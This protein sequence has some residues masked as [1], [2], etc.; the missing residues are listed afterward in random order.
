MYRII[1]AARREIGLDLNVDDS[2]MR[3]GADRVGR[4]MRVMGPAVA[5][6]GDST[7]E[8]CHFTGTAAAWLGVAR[9]VVD[10]AVQ[11]RAKGDRGGLCPASPAPERHGERK[12]SDKPMHGKRWKREQRDERWPWW[13]WKAGAAILLRPDVQRGLRRVF[14]H[15]TG[16]VEDHHVPVRDYHRMPPRVDQYGMVQFLRDFEV[17]PLLLTP[18]EASDLLPRIRN[19]LTVR[20]KKRALRAGLQ[21]SNRTNISQESRMSGHRGSPGE[22]DSAEKE[23]EATLGLEQTLS[24]VPVLADGDTSGRV[25]V[26]RSLT[27][28]PG[29]VDGMVSPPPG[30]GGGNGVSES[31]VDA[32]NN[33]DYKGVH[34]LRSLNADDSFLMATGKGQFDNSIGARSVDQTRTPTSTGKAHA[35]MA[36]STSE[37]SKERAPTTGGSQAEARTG[38]GSF[39]ANQTPDAAIG[40]GNQGGDRTPAN[41]RSAE[42]G[43]LNGSARSEGDVQGRGTGN[44]APRGLFGE[45]GEAEKQSRWST[46]DI[47]DVDGGLSYGTFVASIAQLAEVRD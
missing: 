26:T 32:A 10:G 21:S 33:S 35:H 34:S 24:P 22:V 14:D 2:V 43:P 8:L 47:E 41:W 25:D 36:A 29:S 17:V 20:E 18:R 37:E 28:S 6:R 38:G 23:D 46:V 13:N 1:Q 40:G 19:M 27:R 16:V 31:P 44:S 7:P 12:T 42:T 4:V 9:R 5:G 30:L 39:A 45:A 11:S 3:G 15:Y